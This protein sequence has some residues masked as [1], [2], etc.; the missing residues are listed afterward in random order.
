MT[1]GPA[2]LV[3]IDDRCTACGL[4]LITCAPRALRVAPGRPRVISEVCTA[5]G[6]CVEVCPTG[7]V[8]LVT[9]AAT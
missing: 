1:A 4:C 9:G 5:C 7:A 8:D 2:L 3:R 6:D